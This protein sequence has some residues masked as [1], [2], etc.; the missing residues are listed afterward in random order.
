MIGFGTKSDTSE[1]IINFAIKNGYSMIDTKD[2]NNSIKHFK[3]IKFDRNKVF[4]CSKLVGEENGNNYNPD[5]ILNICNN[6]L[7]ISGLDY[8]DLYYIHTTHSFNN[9]PIISIEDINLVSS[10][11]KNKR[12]YVKPNHDEQIGGICNGYPQRVIFENELTDNSS[13]V[14]NIIIKGFDVTNTECDSDLHTICVNLAN[15]LEQNKNTLKIS[16]VWKR[17]YEVRYCD[18]FINAQ[19]EA[20]HKNIFLNEIAKVYMKVDYNIVTLVKSSFLIFLTKVPLKV[21]IEIV[22]LGGKFVNLTLLSIGPD[23]YSEVA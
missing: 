3:N 14:N 13:T 17:E 1:K 23:S 19:I 11:N 21:K 4:I 9:I 8:W 2:T 10:L 18:N 16:N 5:N 7:A 6:A 15:Y 20:L 22:H 12:V